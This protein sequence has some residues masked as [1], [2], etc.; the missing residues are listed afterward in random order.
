MVSTFSKYEAIN[1]AIIAQAEADVPVSGYNTEFIYTKPLDDQGNIGDP[2]GLDASHM[3]SINAG[4]D[5]NKSDRAIVTPDKKVN[6]YLTQDGKTP[7]GLP[8]T[9]G[10]NFPTEALEGDYCLRL[11]YSPNRLFRYDGRRWIK[12]EDALRTNITPAASDNTTLKNS[13]RTSAKTI[14]DPKGKTK[15]ELQNLNEVFKIKPDN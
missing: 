4:S 6:G 12:V 10:I 3:G 14:K 8:V 5:I 9:S 1:N 15:P 2:Q 11:D 7:N 13:F